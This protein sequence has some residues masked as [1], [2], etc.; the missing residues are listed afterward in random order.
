MSL[1]QEEKEEQN[2]IELEEETAPEEQETSSEIEATPAAAAAD[3]DPGQLEGEA[4]SELKVEAE[5]SPESS[6][7]DV[8]DD[9]PVLPLRGLVVYPMMWLPLTIGQGRSI[10]LVEDTLPQS[11]IIALATSR[12]ESVEEPSPEQIYEIGTAAQVHRVLKAPD[13]TIR[14]AVQGLERIRLK[15]YIQEKP[16]LRARVEVLPETLEEGL[17]LDGTAPGRSGPVPSSG[18]IGRADAR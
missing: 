6:L 2:E 1:E 5:S 9:L 11:R 13:G 14:L 8:A 10:Q 3:I 18:R 15:E 7:D 16:Y 12:D 17:E 4:A